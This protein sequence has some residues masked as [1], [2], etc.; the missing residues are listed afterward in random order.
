[1]E[2]TVWFPGTLGTATCQVRLELV[3][4]ETYLVEAW[5]I[6]VAGNAS[7]VTTQ[8]VLVDGGCAATR[9]GSFG[10]GIVVLALALRR[11]RRRV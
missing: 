9:P 2:E 1:L 10:G 4:D 3:E 6:D 8:D 7:E 11:R 5:T